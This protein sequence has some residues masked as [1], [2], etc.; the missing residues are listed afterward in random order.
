MDGWEGGRGT[1][2]DAA[3]VGVNKT[4]AEAATGRL[5]V[6]ILEA[7]VSSELGC[8]F[9]AGAGVEAVGED[10]DEVMGD[11]EASGAVTATEFVADEPSVE[12]MF[13]AVAEAATAADLAAL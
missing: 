9:V 5:G 11:L 4:S 12:E 2:A 10:I 1:E 13:V 6:E 7:A 8:S 3:L